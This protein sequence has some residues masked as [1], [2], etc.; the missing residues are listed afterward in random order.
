MKKGILIIGA[1]GVSRVATVK[2]AMNIDTFEKITLASR[3]LRKCEMIQKEIKEAQNV[4]IDVA[5]V[6]ADDVPALIKLIKKVNPKQVLNVALPY[7][8]LTIMDACTACGVDYI[9]TANYEHPNEAKFEYKEQWAKDAQFKEANVNALL[10]SGFDPGVTGVFCAYAAKHYFDEIHTIDIMDCNDGDHGYAFATNFNP[11]INLR[12][13]SANGRYWQRNEKGEGE[14][15]ETKPLEVKMDWDYPQVGVKPSYLLYHEE[16]ESLSKN[17]KGIQRIRFFMTFGDSY[18][19]HMNCLQNVGMLGIEP[20]MHQGQEIIPIEF[21][22]TLLPDPA[23]LGPRT[24]GKTN[25]GCV[26]EGI[27]DGVKKKIYIYNVCDH[28]EC[29]KET[30]GQAVSFTTGVPAMIGAKLLY[31]G[32]WSAK[33][34][35][36]I[37]EFDPDPFMEEMMNQGLPWN[38]QEMD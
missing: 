9:D 20:V 3:T 24:V 6:D 33:G 19:Q 4:D 8:D 32:T 27:K 38:I 31:N 12:E 18:I 28:Q 11:E 34:V 30:G 21:L 16:L 23:S 10:G 17:I 1:G 35:Y 15:I 14:W 36:N 22:A 25:I 2:C 7:Q 37:E 5:C 13:V 26:F 29:Y